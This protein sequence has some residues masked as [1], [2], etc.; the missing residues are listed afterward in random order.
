MVSIN[1]SN[2]P[3]NI[4]NHV[5]FNKSKFPQHHLQLLGGYVPITIL[6]KH[7]KRFPQ[8]RLLLLLIFILDESKVGV[9]EGLMQRDKVLERESLVARANIGTCHGFELGDISV[10]AKEGE[11]LA[12]L[13]GGDHAVAVFVKHV[14]DAAE[15]EGVEAGA[16]EAEGGGGGCE[17]D[18]VV[19]SHYHPK[20]K[21]GD[22]MM[23]MNG[24]LME[25]G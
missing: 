14:E 12:D 2:H 7:L 24:E 19:G 11:G 5:P 9:A 15:A 13:G 17:G 23:G 4:I 1:R 3:L 18:V 20:L 16:A 6:I 10:K 21:N 8:I 25:R 22:V